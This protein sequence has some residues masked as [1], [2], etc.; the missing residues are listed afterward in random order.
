M[1]NS[2]TFDVVIA[3]G[4][5]STSFDTLTVP[6]LTPAIGGTDTE[7]FTGINTLIDR[8]NNIVDLCGTKTY[9]I[10]DSS[11]V[12]HTWISVAAKTGVANT[13]TITA[14]PTDDTLAGNTYTYK[15]KVELDKDT[16][17]TQS[18]TFNVAPVVATCSC[19]NI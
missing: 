9:S 14:S 4:C 8:D 17:I 11:N 16:S 7:D 15:L 2:L 6:D 12:A 13:Y 5:L 19:A 1:T 10:L 18:Y 3:D